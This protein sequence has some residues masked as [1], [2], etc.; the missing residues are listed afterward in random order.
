MPSGHGPMG[1]NWFFEEI[2]LKTKKMRSERK[3]GK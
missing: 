2:M 1:W 3:A